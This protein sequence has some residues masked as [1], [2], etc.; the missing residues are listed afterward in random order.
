MSTK[1]GPPES[2]IVVGDSLEILPEGFPDGSVDLVFADPPF[3]IG[4]KYDVHED[5]MTYEQYHAWTGRWIAECWRV[6]RVGGSFWIAINCEF[7]AEV[8]MI[9]RGMETD[10]NLPRDHR[11]VLRNCI[12]WHYTFGQNCQTKFSRCH[13]HLYYWWKG[14]RGKGTFNDM[15]VRVPSARM[16][17]Y[18]DRRQD[19]RGKLPDDVWQYSRICGTFKER[20]AHPCQMPLALMERI[21]VATSNPGDL[22]LDPFSG[23]AVTLVAAA[24]NGRRWT[25]IEKSPAYASAGLGWILDEE[26]KRD[27]TAPATAAY[28][29][30]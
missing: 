2:D 29:P 28:G 15:E 13:T 5:R 6:L 25:G 10:R 9:M 27:Q 17:K 23:S 16:T 18:N 26:K 7:Q 11:P 1:D 24:R 8:R 4:A 30:G 21:V 22:V 19:P 3:N 12:I 20:K 14:T